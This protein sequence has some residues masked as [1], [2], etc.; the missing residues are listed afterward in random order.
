[1]PPELLGLPA[2]NSPNGSVRSAAARQLS[3]ALFGAAMRWAEL[4][5]STNGRYREPLKRRVSG[6]AFFSAVPMP[7]SRPELSSGLEQGEFLGSYWLMSE[8]A[9]FCR[10]HR[11]PSKGNKGPVGATLAEAI[12]CYRQSGSRRPEIKPQFEYNRHVREFYRANP[13]ATN[14]QMLDAWWK[15]RARKSEL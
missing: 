7:Q 15:K 6:T 1:M 3:G 12:A 11:V 8:L 14:Q 9:E 2:A 10:R 5:L 13:G 4:E